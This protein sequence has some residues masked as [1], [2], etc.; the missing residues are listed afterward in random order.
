MVV[1]HL[2]DG[3]LVH[4]G[5]ALRRLVV[6][7][8][9]H[10]EGRG[11]GEGALED[12]AEEASLRVHDGE[13]VVRVAD[14]HRLHVVDAVVRLE[15]G[16]LAVERGAS[17]GDREVALRDEE[18]EQLRGREHAE[19]G[20]V[21]RRDG[22][23]GFARRLQRAQGVDE[24]LVGGEDRHLGADD[25]AHAHVHVGAR[26]RRLESEA[27]EHPLGARGQAA[28]TERLDVP[29]ARAPAQVRERVGAHDRVA[30]R[31]AVPAHVDF[32]ECHAEIIAHLP[33]FRGGLWYNT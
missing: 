21:R 15:D 2:D 4:A 27:L 29:P 7:H 28:R 6:V 14:G 18:G 1:H 20:A 16:H 11:L 5:D 32:P 23:G 3:D 9:D 30:V 31:V 25:V 26:T 8:E 33:P 24:R 13:V 19:E 10:A 12:G 17:G 22:E